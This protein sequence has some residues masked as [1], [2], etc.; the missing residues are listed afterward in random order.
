MI[1]GLSGQPGSFSKEVVEAVSAVNKRPV[2]FALSNPTSKAEC[3]AEQ[4]YRW[5]KGKAI[6]ASGSPFDAVKFGNKLHVPG[7]GNN[8]YIFPG[9]GLGAIVSRSRRVTDEMFLAASFSLASQVTDTDLSMG[10]VYPSL[11]HIRE[12]SALIAY[13]VAKIA[14]SQGLAG[15]EEPE[16]LMAEIREHMFQPIYPHYA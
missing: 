5:S 15:R 7:Q 14:F 3:T 11:S 16:D 9:V 10:S 6:F 8:V 2:I 4:A 12:V 13:E 1:V